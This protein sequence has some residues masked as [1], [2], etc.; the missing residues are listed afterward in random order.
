MTERELPRPLKAARWCLFLTA[1]I[2]L[3]TGIGGLA[4]AGVSGATLGTMT[5]VMLPGILCLAFGLRLR[6]GGRGLFWSIIAVQALVLL[7][8]L[9]NLAGGDP[10]AI[11][12]SLLPVL[13]L[14]FVTRP[15]ARAYLAG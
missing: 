2:S 9:G 14:I 15:A 13:I 10:R 5:W 1:G 3:I 7:L 11:T 12:Q 6:K 8:T 4:A